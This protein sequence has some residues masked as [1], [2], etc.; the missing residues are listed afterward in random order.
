[1]RE[2]GG[3]GSDDGLTTVGK[4]IG[5]LDRLVDILTKIQKSLG[6]YLE[7]Q[8]AAFARFYFVGDEDLLE[9]IG[10]AKD[11]GKIQKHI[12]KMFAGI[13]AL[14]L[15]GDASDVD[16]PPA[17]EILGMISV[18]YERVSFARQARPTKR[19][20]TRSANTIDPR[21]QA[22]KRQA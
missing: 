15:P 13:A 9:I 8:R 5:T 16:A 20:G 1:M 4:R 21:Q 11:P 12:K 10:N 6:D 18:E 7:K 2:L 19:P 3:G 14:D 22:G 17:L